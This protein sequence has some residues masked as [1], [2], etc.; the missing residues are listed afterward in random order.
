YEGNKDYQEKKCFD[1]PQ[2]GGIK[3]KIFFID[4]EMLVGTTNGYK[5]DKSGFWFFPADRDSNN[6]RVFVVNSAVKG[7]KIGMD[8]DR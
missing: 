7:V 8:A 4:G 2:S 5:P 3:I 1:G 6:M